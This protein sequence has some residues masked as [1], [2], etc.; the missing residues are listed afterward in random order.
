MPGNQESAEPAF[1]A[2]PPGLVMDV[3]HSLAN[4]IACDN[5]NVGNEEAKWVAGH[6]ST[7]IKPLTGWK[8]SAAVLAMWVVVKVIMCWQAIMAY[9]VGRRKSRASK[10]K[11]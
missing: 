5:L 6:I 4:R 2:V 7:L 11:L 8:L 10:E 9:A 1:G 3:T